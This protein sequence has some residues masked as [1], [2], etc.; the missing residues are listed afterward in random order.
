MEPLNPLHVASLSSFP[1]PPAPPSQYYMY[2][3]R[4]ALAKA[5]PDN[6]TYEPHEPTAVSAPER[7]SW[8]RVGSPALLIPPPP[9][10]LHLNAGQGV[11]I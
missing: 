2:A 11:P 7:P 6:F 4:M 10:Q 3:R 8:S 5:F 9:S 1:L